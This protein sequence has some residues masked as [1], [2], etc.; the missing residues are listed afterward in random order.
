MNDTLAEL[1]HGAGLGDIVIPRKD[2]I[3]EH[4]HIVALL[5]R[6]DIPA[7]R[8]EAQDQSEELKRM[9]G[10]TR[11]EDVLRKYGLED[12]SYSIKELSDI[13]KVPESIL[14]EVYNRGVG[15]Y[16][17]SPKSV[18]LKHSF[19]KNVDAPMSAKLSKEQWGMSRVYSF[20]DGNEKHDNDL[21]RNVGGYGKA[22]GFIRRMMAENALKHKGNY[23]NPVAP[24]AKDSTMNQPAIFNIKKL[25]NA[26]QNGTNDST[27]GASPFI[28]KHFGLTKGITPYTRK[29][30]PKPP[31]VPYTRKD[32]PAKSAPKETEEQ[33]A[34]RKRW[35]GI[36]EPEKVKPAKKVKAPVDEEER[37][38]KRKEK[39]RER[40]QRR[41]AAVKEA[42]RK[43]AQEQLE[44]NQ[45][46]VPDFAKISPTLEAKLLAHAERNP[47][48]SAFSVAQKYEPTE[49]DVRREDVGDKKDLRRRIEYWFAHQQRYNKIIKPVPTDKYPR[50]PE[51]PAYRLSPEQIKDIKYYGDENA[52]QRIDA[53]MGQTDG[54][55]AQFAP[56]GGSIFPTIFSGVQSAQRAKGKPNIP[57][58]AIVYYLR[59]NHNSWRLR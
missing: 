15:A 6:Y 26:G 17:T 48:L 10:G 57:E 52:Q 29:Y 31:V 46:N 9:T 4:R 23:G 32:R 38:A 39:E 3:K 5:N 1:L 27:Y 56:P 50:N 13:S 24:L 43:A 36:V 16:R 18:R 14:Q 22:S 7:L 19:V 53:S 37:K 8:K 58:D 59:K 34:E 20:L 42:E 33:R 51:E 45:K 12:K 40:G 25:A 35:L 49:E 44:Y 2:F 11:R 28:L 30:A 55:N 47:G 41:R 21:R 54:Y